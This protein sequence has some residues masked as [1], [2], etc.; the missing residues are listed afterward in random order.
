ML[1]LTAT[2][3]TTTIVSVS[4]HFGIPDY[5][6]ATITGAPVPNNLKLSVSRDENKDEVN[7]KI[8]KLWI[9]FRLSWTVVLSFLNSNRFGDIFY[10]YLFIVY[11]FFCF[12]FQMPYACTVCSLFDL[13]R[14]YFPRPCWICCKESDSRVVNRSL[15]TAPE[16]NRHR[17]FQLSSEPVW[18]TKI[19]AYLNL[20]T[21]NQRK[22][23]CLILTMFY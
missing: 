23:V 10:N 8:F 19:L 15:F 9:N 21:P 7:M 1:G 20:S 2:A 4:Q 18:R 17:E 12:I 14:I 3:T 11:S 5:K 22:K 13:C 6:T 16:G